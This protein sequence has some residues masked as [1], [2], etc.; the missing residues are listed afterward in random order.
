MEV[1]FQHVLQLNMALVALVVS[2][3]SQQLRPALPAAKEHLACTLCDQ[4]DKQVH[5]TCCCACDGE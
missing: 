5:S 1:G 4:R 2:T 3:Q